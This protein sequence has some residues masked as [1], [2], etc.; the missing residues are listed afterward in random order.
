MY[1][2]SMYKFDTNPVRKSNRAAEL[3]VT[4][5]T[6]PDNPFPVYNEVM[7]RAD[8]RRFDSPAERRHFEDVAGVAGNSCIKRGSSSTGVDGQT[9]VGLG[10]CRLDVVSLPC[11]N[12]HII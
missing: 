10:H 9:T 4:C 6:H 11:I 12:L 5:S 2:N 3:K 7:I 1:A 8:S